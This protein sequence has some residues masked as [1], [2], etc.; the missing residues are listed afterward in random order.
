MC[1]IRNVINFTSKSSP[2]NHSIASLATRCIPLVPCS[3]S[4]L[5][6]ASTI[7]IVVCSVSPQSHIAL[8]LQ[9]HSYRR[10]PHFPRPVLIRLIA[11]AQCFLGISMPSVF[12]P[13]LVTSSLFVTNAFPHSSFYTCQPQKLSRIRFSAVS[14]GGFLDFS[15][16][17][18]LPSSIWNSSDLLWFKHNKL[19]L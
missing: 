17:T 15:L 12:C 9:C 3:N 4:L 7:C 16:F 10:E 13:G 5:R 18:G 14:H 2:F 1:K 19:L 8:S 6:H 11:V